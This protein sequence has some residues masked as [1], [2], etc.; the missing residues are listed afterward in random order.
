MACSVFQGIIPGCAHDLSHTQVW[1]DQ[2][3]GPQLKQWLERS[4]DHL[5][6][7]LQSHDDHEMPMNQ[8]GPRRTKKS[9]TPSTN[10]HKS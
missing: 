3:L 6:K 8:S 9:H 2:R 1:E 4:D 5:E 10:A 7:R